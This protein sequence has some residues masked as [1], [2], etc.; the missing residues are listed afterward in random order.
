M[1]DDKSP[2]DSQAV[3]TET[4]DRTPISPKIPDRKNS[5][6]HHLLHRPE[7]AELVDRELAIPFAF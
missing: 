5:L 6:E 4:I 1:A 7:R 3:A 2:A